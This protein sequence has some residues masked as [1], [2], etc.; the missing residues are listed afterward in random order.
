MNTYSPFWE[1]KNTSVLG[2]YLA[3]YENEKSM[4]MATFVD[5]LVKKSRTQ[6]R[7]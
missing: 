7:N 5:V 1:S 2:G 6:N 4:K 3:A